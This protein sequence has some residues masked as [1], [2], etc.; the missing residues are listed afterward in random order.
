MSWS[1]GDGRAG[2]Y[3][4][5]TAPT[6]LVLVVAGGTQCDTDTCELQS[7]LSPS[8]SS[9][10]SLGPAQRGL[11]YRCPRRSGREVVGHN[12]VRVQRG[13][14]SGRGTELSESLGS[15]SGHSSPPHPS[16]E[17]LTH[18]Y[19]RHPLNTRSGPALCQ[20]P[21]FNG[22]SISSGRAQSYWRGVP[23]SCVHPEGA[24]L[25]VSS[26]AGMERGQE[27][28]GPE[29]AP[30]SPVVVRKGFLEEVAAE[31]SFEG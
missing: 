6:L 18:S 20:G 17:L 23:N 3:W 2:G 12:A 19:Y 8:D 10:C 1:H 5:E 25:D 31:L 26:R 14:H 4:G 9:S 15:C 7:F 24:G 16:V 21:Q 27:Q 13:L 30:G 28:P 22:H 11:Q 29:E